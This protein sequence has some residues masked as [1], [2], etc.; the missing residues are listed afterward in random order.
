[1]YQGFLHQKILQGRNKALILSAGVRRE[2]FSYDS[3]NSFDLA[4]THAPSV[5]LR[6]HGMF[7]STY[8]PRE[9]TRVQVYVGYMPKL[10]QPVLD[11]SFSFGNYWR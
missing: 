8:A 2:R 1:M 3:R 10:D 4:I 9:G 11:V 5:G 6:L 7:R